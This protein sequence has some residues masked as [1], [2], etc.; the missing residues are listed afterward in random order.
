[1]K[2]NFKINVNVEFENAANKKEDVLNEVKTLI[3]SFSFNNG[4]F[5][6]CVI[7]KTPSL[8]D[9]FELDDIVLTQTNGSSFGGGR[10]IV[11]KIIEIIEVGNGHQDFKIGYVTP[12][13]RKN[14]IIRPAH[15]IRRLDDI[16]KEIMSNY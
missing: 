11:G 6:L 5:D 12:T 2:E 14:S 7:E 15:Q 3:N 10:A 4:S 9:Q 1:M 13:G 16:L 8:S